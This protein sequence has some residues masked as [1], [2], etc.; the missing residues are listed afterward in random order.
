MRYIKLKIEDVA[1]LKHLHQNI[2]NYT[3]RK[4]S[5]C[6]VLSNQKHKIKDLACVFNVSRRTIERWFDKWE[7]IG[8]DSL[9][10]A[11]G[12]GA[13]TR[14]EDYSKKVSEQL[15]IHNRNLK[16]VLNYFEE[17]HNIII[18]KKNIAEFFKRYLAI[19]GNGCDSL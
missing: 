1:V 14:L 10:V 18:C 16:N 8:V 13:K 17:K 7:E 4:R 9:A 2:P 3:V 12:R 15:E 11:E 19:A 5:H 6:L